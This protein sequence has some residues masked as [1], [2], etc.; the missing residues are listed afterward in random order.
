MASTSRRPRQQSKTPQPQHHEV[1]LLTCFGG[2]FLLVIFSLRLLLVDWFVFVCGTEAPPLLG[3]MAALLPHPPDWGA[4]ASLLEPISQAL[5]ARYFFSP[6]P[7]EEQYRR[8][9][10]RLS[11]VLAARHPFRRR[12]AAPPPH[13]EG[14][15]EGASAPFRKPFN[16]HPT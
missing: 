10:T 15:M 3:T 4:M 8:S 6:G 9:T 7:E 5:S 13:N 2:W 16:F 12:R 14:K 1:C 11:R